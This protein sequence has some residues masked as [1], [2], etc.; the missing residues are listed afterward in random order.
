MGAYRTILTHLSQRYTRERLV[1]A[2][3]INEGGNGATPKYSNG[4]SNGNGT[5]PLPPQACTCSP[6]RPDPSTGG[7]GTTPLP[8][9]PPSQAAAAAAAAAAAGGI[10]VPGHTP[11]A[12]SG[13]VGWADEGG[14][15]ASVV[16]F[17]LMA[18]NLADLATA[19]SYTPRI[20]HFFSA[21]QR[22]LATQ[23]E[24]DMAEQMARSVQI[25]RELAVGRQL[26]A[27]V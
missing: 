17:D 27:A 25:E 10:A 23:R 21:E 2:A 11:G 16:A 15:G 14:A 1:E 5:T 12:V 26:A 4:N 18:F 22:A 24:A 9:P 6:R 19:P 3:S 20:L 8:P 13:A 7:N